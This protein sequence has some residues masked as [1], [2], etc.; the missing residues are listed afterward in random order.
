[1]EPKLTTRILKYP[2]IASAVIAVATALVW[3]VSQ[4]Y[5]LPWTGFGDYTKPN[6]EFVRGK[7]LWDWLQLFIIPIFLS[8]GVFLLNRS[9]RERERL[10]AEERTKLERDLAADRQQEAALQ[11]YFDRMSELLLKEKL[12]TTDV[13]EARN[14]ARIRTL[15]ILRGLD[16]QRKGTVLIFLQEAGLL[17]HFD[18]PPI[19]NL[20]GADLSGISLN[21]ETL[22]SFVDLRGASLSS[23]N[24]SGADLSHN[25]LRGTNLSDS[26]L[27]ET[28]LRGTSLLEADLSRAIMVRANLT[29]AI[30][31]KANLYH[32]DLT[33][34]N[35]RGA[36]LGSGHKVSDGSCFMA[37]LWS[38]M[39]HLVTM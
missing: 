17:G 14:V 5:S 23:V 3:I 9:E 19:I 29:D 21:G 13:E 34:A 38:M 6:G 27:S 33:N 12:R 2:L 31:A 39:N 4:G 1:M 35:L 36:N 28:T 32:A 11:T 15:S 25:A 30:L 26:N 22:S 8:V 37:R 16:A 20:R 10:R 7:T 18:E 24:L